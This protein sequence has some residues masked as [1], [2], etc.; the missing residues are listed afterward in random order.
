MTISVILAI[1]GIVATVIS[2]K[3]IALLFVIPLLLV[4]G[5]KVD[6]LEDRIYLLE[7]IAYDSRDKN[8]H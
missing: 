3:T 1:L 7:E 6:E 8:R 4:L 2:G 5:Q